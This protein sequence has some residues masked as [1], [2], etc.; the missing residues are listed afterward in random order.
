MS[1]T[2]TKLE[3][4]SQMP[5]DADG[6]EDR[7]QTLEKSSAEFGSELAGINVTLQYMGKG[8]DSIGSKLDS[9]LTPINA[10]LDKT[11]TR[12]D[13]HSKVIGKLN[14]EAEAKKARWGNIK[15]LI[16]AGMIAGAGVVGKE[17]FVVIWHLFSH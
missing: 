13:E 1:S 17:L 12:A 14:E 5:Y 10:R 3:V 6:H 4:L 8:I 7:L 2:A 15:K 11:D 9:F 16:Y